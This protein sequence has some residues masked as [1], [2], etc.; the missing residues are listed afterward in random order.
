MI[1]SWEPSPWQ[2]RLYCKELPSNLQD[3]ITVLIINGV[4]IYMMTITTNVIFIIITSVT[5]IHHHVCFRTKLK[6]QK[7]KTNI[8]Q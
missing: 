3:N 1:W 2:V 6:K 4:Y 7:Q 8:Q 5:V